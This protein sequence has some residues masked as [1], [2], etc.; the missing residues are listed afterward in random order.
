MEIQT[1]LKSRTGLVAGFLVLLIVI[2]AGFAPATRTIV[3]SEFICFGCHDHAE[4][5]PGAKPAITK[6]HPATK[7][8]RP[9]RCVECHVPDSLAGSV[10]VYTHIVS[11]TDLFGNWRLSGAERT[12]PYYPPIA[13]KAYAVRD[14]MLAAD[15]SPCR[16][17]HIE[18]EIKPK[19][20]RGQNAHKK[21]LKKNQTCMECHTDLVHREVPLRLE[22]P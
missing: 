14:A 3:A 5:A 6:I 4:Y 21:A 11:N 16:T 17:C 13:R 20:K 12:G 7:G 15:S 10:F 8:G 9:T 19:R 18:E 2:L 22:T 1:F